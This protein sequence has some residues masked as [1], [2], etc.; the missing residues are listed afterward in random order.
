MMEGRTTGARGTTR[1]THRERAGT[2]RRRL[3][4]A[5]GAWAIGT[6]T[7]LAQPPAPP[8]A[9]SLAARLGSDDFADREAAARALE[10]RG[11]AAL[12]ALL[13]AA[14]SDDPEVRRRAAALA[15]KI[16]RTAESTRRL[17]PKAVALN[18]DRVALGTALHDLKQKTGLNLALDPNRVSDPLR[19]I[20]V[21]TG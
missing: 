6:G 15:D 7:G 9:E 19:P 4:A 20:T 21:R 14:S 8:S 16:K 1:T 13:A 18:Y 5:V 2:M 10:A 11:E 3:L 17:V 12:P